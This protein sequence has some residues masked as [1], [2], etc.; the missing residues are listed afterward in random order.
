MILKN[1][2]TTKQNTAEF[3]QYNLGH[4]DHNKKCIKTAYQ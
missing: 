2:K 3:A 4:Q 1:Q